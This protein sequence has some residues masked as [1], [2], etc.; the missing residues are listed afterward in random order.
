[1]KITTFILAAAALVALLVY[2]R[3]AANRNLIAEHYERDH[4][5]FN[6]LS[7]KRLGVRLAAEPVMT[8]SLRP[9]ADPFSAGKEI[10]GDPRRF[11]QN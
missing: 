11:S 4:R 9:V 7:E 10:S 6:E 3:K 1:M 2:I 5:A 8:Q